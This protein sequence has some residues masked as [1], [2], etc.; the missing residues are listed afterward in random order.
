M[1]TLIPKLIYDYIDVYQYVKWLGKIHV[2]SMNAGCVGHS[3]AV[4]WQKSPGARGESIMNLTRRAVI[5]IVLVVLFGLTAAPVTRAQQTQCFTLSA[6]DCTLLTAALGNFSQLKSFSYQVD[7]TDS[8]TDLHTNEFKTS[9]SGQF[10]LGEVSKTDPLATLGTVQFSLDAKL[11]SNSGTASSFKAMLIDNIFYYDDG[12]SVRG[13]KLA[14]VMAPTAGQTGSTLS[15]IQNLQDPA[16]AAALSALFATPGLITVEK[17]TTGPVVAG[18][19]Q[20]TLDGQPLTGFVFTVDVPTLVQSSATQKLLTQLFGPVSLTADQIQMLQK[21]FK[22]TPL[23]LTVW[24]GAEDKLF[25]GFAIN[26]TG[27]IDPKDLG[28]TGEVTDTTFQVVISLTKVGKPVT[29][30]APANAQIVDLAEMMAGM[31]NPASG[32]AQPT[33]AAT[34]SAS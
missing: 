10:Q 26:F 11:S 25:H 2:D 32:T 8:W 16:T 24:I 21:A 3:P 30:T 1:V 13:F 7:L 12:A 29:L 9:G 5:L 14:G 27:K 4:G 20:T 18:T 22:N 15:L 6:G 17:T 23:K 28:Q 19:E 31:M 34:Q 33:P